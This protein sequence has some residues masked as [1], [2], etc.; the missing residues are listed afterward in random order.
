MTVSSVSQHVYSGLCSESDATRDS[1]DK[2][3]HVRLI[4]ALDTNNRKHEIPSNLD[5]KIK[6]HMLARI[7]YL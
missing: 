6:F 5:V 3:H 7:G 1:T 4:L 2:T